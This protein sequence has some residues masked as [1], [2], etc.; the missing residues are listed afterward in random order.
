M[1]ERARASSNIEIR[2]DA[3]KAQELI[4]KLQ[5]INGSRGS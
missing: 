2:E 3:E 5:K 4:K 1:Y